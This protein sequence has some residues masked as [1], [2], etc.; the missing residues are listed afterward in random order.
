M[1]DERAKLL[2]A[3][4]A[5]VAAVKGAATK[6]VEAR[7]TSYLQQV[8]DREGDLM[9][10]REQYAAVQALYKARVDDLKL[11][12][13]DAA[14]RSAKATEGRLVPLSNKASARWVYGARGWLARADDSVVGTEN[15]KSGIVRVR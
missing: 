5:E 8:E 10:V 2:E 3:A 12:V 15:R 11:K 6:E 14:T 1:A 7:V 13:H 9:L 4:N